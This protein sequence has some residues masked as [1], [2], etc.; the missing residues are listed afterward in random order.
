MQYIFITKDF[1]KKST[2]S[3][4]AA[5]TKEKLLASLIYYAFHSLLS[6]SPQLNPYQ[7]KP[8]TALLWDCVTFLCFKSKFKEMSCKLIQFFEIRY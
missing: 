6:L 7:R 5:G 8:L 1:T 3:Y 4:E 2:S